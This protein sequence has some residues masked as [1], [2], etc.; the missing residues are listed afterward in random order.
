MYFWHCRLALIAMAWLPACIEGQGEF[1]ITIL[2]KENGTE[3]VG[4]VVCVV[5]F[6]LL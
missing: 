3:T 2:L 5:K 6:L 4:C 1:S